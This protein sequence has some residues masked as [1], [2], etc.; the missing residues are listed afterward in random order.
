M[1]LFS[2]NNNIKKNCFSALKM[3][4]DQICFVNNT[5]AGSTLYFFRIKKNAKS[6]VFWRLLNLEFI[7][8]KSRPGLKALQD[9]QV[10]L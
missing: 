4:I 2:G 6:D 5:I 8:I 7:R 1:K 3:V 9:F 10:A